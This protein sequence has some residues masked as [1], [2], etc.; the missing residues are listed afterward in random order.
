MNEFN[1]LRNKQAMLYNFLYKS[2]QMSQE[3]ALTD[4]LI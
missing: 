3:Q 4:H 2:V 1:M